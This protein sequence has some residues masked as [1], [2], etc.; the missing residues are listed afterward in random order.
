V[1]AVV[2][3]NR[4]T[5]QEATLSGTRPYSVVGRLTSKD[6][7]RRI[8]YVYEGVAYGGTEEYILLML[9]YLDPDRYTPI[10][11]TPGNNYRF[12][13]PLFI[14]KL[15]QLGVPLIY[16][17][18]RPTS[19]LRA[20]VS[21]TMNM[22]RVFQDT[23]TDVVHIHSQRPDGGRRATIA[24]RLAGVRAVLRSEHLPPSSNMSQLTRFIIK[25]QDWLTDSII[26][27]SE[28]CLEEHL[29]LLRRDSLKTLRVYYGIELDRFNP[30]HDV[31]AAKRLLGLDP[32]IT[33][34]GKIARL[35][36]EKGHVYF[37][38]AAAEVVRQYGPV[39]FLLVG[40][41]PLEGE[42][43]ARVEQLGLGDH[44]RFL[45]FSHDTV[46]SIQAMDI[47][48]MSS[49]SEG[50]SL[51][52]LEY[53]AMGKPIV[54]TNEPSFVE[55]V[56]DGESGVVV[57]LQDAIALA[58]GILRVLRD[59]QLAERIARGA[60]RRVHAEFDIRCNLRRMMRLYDQF[61]P[62]AV[63]ARGPVSNSE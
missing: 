55:T 1:P 46:P 33:T 36:P 60:H 41:G 3:L 48:V 40:D 15:Q 56:V 17:D 11:V 10:I 27:G 53:M 47:T 34:V 45:G 23:E 21:D 18:P 2:W 51:A 54:S 8:A 61:Q 26:A 63:V 52:M 9:R 20:G 5:T 35:S 14:E 38:D 30:W 24:A 6:G 16:T 42:L 22:V 37:L 57:E 25:P 12:C 19:R 4:I 7:A 62:P 28:S 43:R 13:P 58:G 50:I 29:R 59:P 44:V 39:N 49:V 31:P 32:S